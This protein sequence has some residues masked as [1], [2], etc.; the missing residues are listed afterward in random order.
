MTNAAFFRAA[1]PLLLIAGGPASAQSAADLFSKAPPPIDDALRARVK[2][3]YQAHVEAKW[4]LADKVVAE[5]SKDTF[6]GADKIQIKDFEITRINY[7]ENFTQAEVVVNTH[8]DWA[9]RGNRVI[10]PMPVNSLWKVID[11]EWY[12]YTVPYTGGP[13]ATPFGTMTGGAD[14]GPRVAIP[15]DPNQLAQQLLN[16]IQ[17]DKTDVMLSSY[18]TAQDQIVLTNQTDGEVR[19]EVVLDGTFPGLSATIDK[20]VVAAH[21]KATVLLK[22][23]PKDRSPKPMV[24]GRINVEPLSRSFAFRIQFAVPPNTVLDEQKKQLPKP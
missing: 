15:G 24:A 9:I 19:V 5:D 8:R 12:W 14:T 22:I 2:Q 17:V 3:F 23:D 10:V 16:K 1:L 21:D 18:Q 6:L 20:P 11:G 7:K 4:R 13:R